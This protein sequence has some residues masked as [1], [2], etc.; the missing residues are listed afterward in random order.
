MILT[1]DALHEGLH[2][3]IQNFGLFKIIYVYLNFSNYVKINSH[4]RA[5]P[6]SHTS[7]GMYSRKSGESH[8]QRYR[9]QSILKNRKEA[10]NS[11]KV[12]NTSESEDNITQKILLFNR[13]SSIVP[14]PSRNSSISIINSKPAPMNANCMNNSQTNSNNNL[15]LP[16][17]AAKSSQNEALKLYKQSGTN[18][19]VSIYFVFF[20]EKKF[21]LPFFSLF[22]LYFYL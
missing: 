19:Y 16:Q 2:E 9:S 20:F 12:A 5:K 17:I 4:A 18:K 11:N 10:Q 8:E 6:E 21:P 13:P 14:N 22:L 3:K 1:T 15:Q 7:L